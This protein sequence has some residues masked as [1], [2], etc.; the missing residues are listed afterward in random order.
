MIRAVVISLF[1]LATVATSACNQTVA[2]A[3]EAARQPTRREMIRG[4]MRASVWHLIYCLEEDQDDTELKAYLEEIAAAQPRGKRIEVLNCRDLP[5]GFLAHNSVS[6]FGSVLPAGATDYGDNGYNIIPHRTRKADDVVLLPYF[7]SPWSSGSAVAG[8]FLADQPERLLTTLRGEMRND[9]QLLFRPSWAYELHAAN[10]DRIYGNFKDTTWAFD[11]ENEIE[12][13]APTAP[14]YE[15]DS[16]RIFAYDGVVTK[17]HTL[18]VANAL[19]TISELTASARFPEVRLYPNLERLGLRRGT[20]RPVQYE[21][22]AHVL[23]IA[24]AFTSREDLLLDFAAWEPFVIP[25]QPADTHGAEQRENTR[26]TIARRQRQHA[27]GIGTESFMA[28]QAEALR[29][30]ATG[31]LEEI[32]PE[33]ASDFLLEARAR[34]DA[35]GGSPPR[36]APVARRPGADSKMAGMTFAHQGYRVHNGYGGE[37]IKPS[38]DSLARLHVNALAVVPYTFMRNPN[39]PGHFFVPSDAGQENDWATARS[40]REAKEK[41]WYVLLKPQIWVGGGHWPG[42]V[43][44]TSE[45]DWDAFFRYYTSWIVHYAVL[46]ERE[47]IDGLCLGT[48]LVQTTLK[49]PD[50]WREII[51]KVRTV[52]GGQLT[53]AANWGEEFENFRFW[54]DL[55]AIGLNSYYPLSDQPAPTDAELLAGAR[56]WLEMAALTSRRESRPLWLTEVGYRSVQGAWRNPH[57]DAGERPASMTDQARCYNALLTAAADVPELRAFFFW[58]WPTYLGHGRLRG[59]N[60]YF[61]PGGKPAA[62]QLAAFNQRWL[63]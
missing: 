49:H 9:F 34:I 51:R 21:V 31:V 35:L 19:Q 42:D 11:L 1:L 54:D 39:K 7:N 48:E 13:S 24:P 52:Y 12:M 32:A 20:M 3:E 58:K 37:K 46:A 28:R 59:D 15:Q 27:A 62:Q 16:L 50:R 18:L 45:E 6:V 14:I 36:I 26:I 29:L 43:D 25:P 47:N 44:F 10:G 4:A 60:R 23:H 8:F 22:E 57:A 38:L 2:Q 30:H 5:N 56:R 55:D 61:T 17:A 33:D 40:A 53:Y 63:R 41:D